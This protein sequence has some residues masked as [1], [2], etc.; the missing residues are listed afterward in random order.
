[1]LRTIRSFRTPFDVLCTQPFQQDVFRG[2]CDT[3]FVHLREIAPHSVYAVPAR[4]PLCGRES[5]DALFSVYDNSLW[6]FF[7]NTLSTPAEV[8]YPWWYRYFRGS[9]RG[10]WGISLY[11]AK[12]CSVRVP[13]LLVG[14]QV[15][16]GRDC[17]NGG[18]GTDDLSQA[19]S[20][21]RQRCQWGQGRRPMHTL[22]DV[23]MRKFGAT[24]LSRS[25]SSLACI[26]SKASRVF[27]YMKRA[28][29]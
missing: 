13:H 19:V 6:P 22:T 10:L 26:Q 14:S 11:L 12:L 27:R 29:R 24:L 2:S 25:R 5:Q 18:C 21:F 1:M 16:S 3:R 9:A 15:L 4:A 23:V 28:G 8:A 20:Q 17:S 7:G